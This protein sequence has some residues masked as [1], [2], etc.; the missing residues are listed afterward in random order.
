MRLYFNICFFSYTLL[1]LWYFSCLLEKLDSIVFVQTSKVELEYASFPPRVTHAKKGLGAES[2]KKIEFVSN[3]CKGVSCSG[4]RD[5]QRRNFSRTKE[6]P[7]LVPELR[8]VLRNVIN[9]NKE[10]MLENENNALALHV[11]SYLE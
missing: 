2:E 10:G 11:F 8:A 3:E 4:A 6:S 1:Y 5:S 9:W 7:I